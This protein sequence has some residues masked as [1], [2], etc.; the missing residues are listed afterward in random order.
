MMEDLLGKFLQNLTTLNSDAAMN[1]EGAS[2][3]K[4]LTGEME[5][6]LIILYTLICGTG[7]IANITLISVILGKIFFY[8]FRR[9]LIY[10]KYLNE[11]S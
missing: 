10:G 2:S 1:I 6:I 3:K 11:A 9:N 7:L 4:L 5:F 8:Q